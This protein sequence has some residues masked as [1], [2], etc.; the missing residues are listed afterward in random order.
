MAKAKKPKPLAVRN[1]ER[2]ARIRRVA[3][4]SLAALVFVALLGAGFSQLRSFVERGVV[5]PRRPPTVVMKTRPAWMSDAR[6]IQIINSVRPAGTHSA[7]DRQLLADT[8][9][10]LQH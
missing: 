10:I 7:F 3:L 9:A 8:A 5:S 2:I 4:H 1:P 6:A